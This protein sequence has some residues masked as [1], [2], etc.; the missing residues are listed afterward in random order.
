MLTLRNIDLTPYNTLGIA[1]QAHTMVEIREFA[2]LDDLLALQ[3]PFSVLGGGSNVVFAGNPE[4][5]IALMR[6]QGRALAGETD[7]AWLVRAMAG[8]NWHELVCWT[9]QN[10]WPG[11]EN[12]SLIPGTVGAAPIQNIGAYG[13]ELCDR[14]ESLE[15]VAVATG[16]RKVFTRDDCRFSYRDSLFKQSAGAW[17]ITAVTLRL[18]KPWKPET[19]YRDLTL[20]LHNAG[21]DAPTPQQVSDAVMAIRQRKLP[22]WKILGNAG[23][24]FKNPVVQAP[25]LRQLQA[26]FPDLAFYA[27]PDGSAKLA[28]GWLIEKA[29]WKGRNLGN[30]AVHDRQALVLVNRGGATGTEMLDLAEQIARDVAFQFSVNLEREPVI[31]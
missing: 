20:E 23:S 22:D 14:F 2:E 31:L 27:Q 6:M 4:Q 1:A 15:A 26:R 28:A 19:S 7:T 8:E 11:L 13:V 12:L 21:A 5:T 29:G 17:V 16:E 10:G 30:A 9:L 24:F 25:A 3:K 18:P